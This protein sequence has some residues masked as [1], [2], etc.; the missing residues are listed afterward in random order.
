MFGKE[1]TGLP[2][3]FM[4]EHAEKALRIPQNDTNIRSLNV[5]NTASIIIYEALRQQGFPNLDLTQD[6]DYDKLK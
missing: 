6:Y 4:N 5:S 1:T 3:M 2:E